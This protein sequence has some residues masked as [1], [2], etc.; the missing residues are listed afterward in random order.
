[1]GNTLSPQHL[2]GGNRTHTETKLSKSLMYPNDLSA[3]PLAYAASFEQT[4]RTP[5]TFVGVT[6][7]RSPSWRT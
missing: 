7:T 2:R 1:M 6:V 4:G 5:S 3:H